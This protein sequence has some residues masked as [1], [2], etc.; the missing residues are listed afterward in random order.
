[1]A[2]KLSYAIDRKVITVLFKMFT[3][4]DCPLCPDMKELSERLLIDGHLITSYEL[5]TADGL[6]ES[7]MCE[8][9]STPSL[10]L[11]D[12]KDNEITGWRGIVP[13]FDEVMEWL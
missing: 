4:V 8:V 5:D 9:M 13:N 7:I 6:T 1:M 3:K 11:I 2:R 10:I 12:D